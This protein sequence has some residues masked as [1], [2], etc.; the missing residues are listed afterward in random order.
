VRAQFSSHATVYAHLQNLFL[1]TQQMQTTGGGGAA[2]A[3]LAAAAAAAAGEVPRLSFV[4]EAC[5]ALIY[6]TRLALVNG[7]PPLAPCHLH[8]CCRRA[9]NLQIRVPNLSRAAHACRG[10]AAAL[11]LLL[12]LPQT[13]VDEVSR[14]QWRLLLQPRHADGDYQSKRPRWNS[15]P[16]PHTAFPSGQGRASRAGEPFLVPPRPGPLQPWACRLDTCAS[17]AAC[18]TVP[19]TQASG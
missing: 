7:A 2:G 11:P 17:C 14:L 4:G 15:P 18:S 9:S 3:A 19:A 12:V 8:R 5:E 16:D 1:P 13:L 10:A 6:Y